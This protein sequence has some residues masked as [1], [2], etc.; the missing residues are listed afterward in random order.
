M[1]VVATVSIR[2][3]LIAIDDEPREIEKFESERRWRNLR[4]I[5]R[6]DV[7]DPMIGDAMNL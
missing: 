5:L 7:C 1:I 3:R 6:S 4:V 2:V